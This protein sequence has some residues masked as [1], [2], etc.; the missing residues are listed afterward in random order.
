MIF[1]P[2][3]KRERA[4]KGKVSLFTGRLDNEGQRDDGGGAASVSGKVHVKCERLLRKARW[5]REQR[6]Y[7][8]S[9]SLHVMTIVEMKKQSLS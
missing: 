7:W 8:V 9:E 3:E 1:Q 5:S 4:K 2:K 6:V